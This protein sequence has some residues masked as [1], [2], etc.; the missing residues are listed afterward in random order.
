MGPL[1]PKQ[2]WNEILQRHA[3]NG[4]E[5]FLQDNKD[6]GIHFQ[7]LIISSATQEISDVEIFTQETL[8]IVASSNKSTEVGASVYNYLKGYRL[9]KV[10]IAEY[11][12]LDNRDLRETTC[13]VLPELFDSILTDMTDTAM[14]SIRHVLTTAVRILWVTKD[15]TGSP[16]AAMVNGIIRTLRWER[17]LDESNLVTLSF[18]SD[19]KAA[20][21]IADIIGRI[22]KYQFFQVHDQRHA[23]YMYRSGLVHINRLYYSQRVNNFLHLKTA[24]PNPQYKPLGEDSSRALSL[25]VRTPGLLDSLEF[26]DDSKCNVP[27]GDREIEVRIQ[28]TGLNF[29]DVMVAMNEIDDVALGLEAGGI[30]TRL[31][32]DNPQKLEVGDRVMILSNI[33]GCFQTYARTT[34]DLAI[35]IP[36]N[37]SFEVAAAIPVTFSTAY[38]CLVDIARLA[39]GDSILIHAAAGGVGQAAIMLA[40]HLGAVVYVTVSSEEKRTL[41]ME[42]YNIPAE[43]VLSSRGLSFAQ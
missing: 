25:T 7:S 27:L 35:K 31:G 42:T 10:S 12:D 22:F 32:I 26:V 41:I 15:M 6:P 20:D 8:I 28:A 17:D 43:H 18:G 3:F 29:R 36:D 21:K 11:T 5:L 40:Q 23:E 38:Y 2:G 9:D 16:E 14:A 13:V 30:I 19:N 1:L 24:K 37:M 4:T 39:R 34:Q 33:S